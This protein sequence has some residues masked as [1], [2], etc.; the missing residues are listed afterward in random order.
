MIGEDKKNE[1]HKDLHDHISSE[2]IRCNSCT[3]TFHKQRDQCQLTFYRKNPY[4][5]SCLKN[6]DILKYNPYYQVLETSENES[7]KLYFQNQ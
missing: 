3:S 5:L 2:S 4:C 1:Y 7:E 6:K